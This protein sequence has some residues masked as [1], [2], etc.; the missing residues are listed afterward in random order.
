MSTIKPILKYPGA[1]WR[2]APWI[3]SFF[4]EH[5][6]Y[7]EPYCGSAACFFTKDPSPHEVINDL[8]SSLVNLFRIIRE[9]GTEL[10]MLIEMTPWAREEYEAV[11]RDYHGTGDDLEDA[12]RFLIRC[13]QAH[14]T[15]LSST[16]GWRHK[17]VHGDS[18]ETVELWNKLPERIL[19]TVKRLKQAEIEHRPAL[20]IIARYNAP[21][22]LLNVDPPYVRSTRNGKFYSHEM[23]DN[24]HLDLIEAL[25]R[26]SG[27]VVL[28]GYAHSLYEEKLAHWQQ[29]T[30]PAQAEHG[31]MRTEV[32]WL[33]EK[34]SASRQ[35][36]LFS[37]ESEVVA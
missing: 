7:V 3:T 2:L 18:G 31:Q 21:D 10:A 15:R 4:P 30:M 8:D 22:V 14:G 20:D 24:D 19:A 9:R 16:S 12:R 37:E 6:H 23:D 5:E 36:P 28:S 17:G 35:L 26:H 33:N 29:V 34:A 11:G 32:L 13:W 27:P 1:K 25:N